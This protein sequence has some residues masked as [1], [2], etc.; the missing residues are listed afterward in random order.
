VYIARALPTIG[1]PGTIGG[2]G[3]LLGPLFHK[4]GEVD[5]IAVISKPSLSSDIRNIASEIIDPTQLFIHLALPFV[6]RAYL[7]NYL[8]RNFWRLTHKMVAIRS[9]I[10][11]RYRCLS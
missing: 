9:F 5:V 2:S 3:A 10:I 4:T 8:G 11:R 1:N 7:Q 6:N